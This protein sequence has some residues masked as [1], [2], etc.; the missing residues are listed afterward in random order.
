MDLTREWS[1]VAYR[2]VKQFT[3]HCGICS[4]C[5][6]GAS[7]HCTIKKKKIYNDLVRR[8]GYGQRA[9]CLTHVPYIIGI[10]LST[11]HT[12]IMSKEVEYKWSRTHPIQSE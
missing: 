3:V 4:L 12:V 8:A 1:Q 5:V 11:N 2:S 7:Y 6:I 10:V 9:L